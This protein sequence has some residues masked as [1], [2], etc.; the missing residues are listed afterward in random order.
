[1]ET[2]GRAYQTDG[3]SPKGGSY[4]AG[5]GAVRKPT[6]LKLSEQQVDE[7]REGVS[8]WCRSCGP[9]TQFVRI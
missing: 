2:W 6:R 8:G 5:L 9:R 4:L 7:V 3:R 1:M